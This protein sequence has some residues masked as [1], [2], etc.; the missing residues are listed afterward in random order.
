MWNVGKEGGEVDEGGVRGAL[1]QNA[2]E[3]EGRRQIEW[4]R[5]YGCD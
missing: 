4:E 2:F 5:R 3:N 1:Q